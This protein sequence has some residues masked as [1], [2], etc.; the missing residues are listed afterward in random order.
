MRLF[1]PTSLPSMPA[2]SVLGALAGL[3]LAVAAVTAA[4]AA[5]CDFDLVPDFRPGDKD[6]PPQITLGGQ[7]TPL[8]ERRVVSCRNKVTVE[9]G[10]VYLVFDDK[11]KLTRKECRPNAPCTPSPDGRAFLSQLVVGL[12]GQ[13]V[14]GKKMD[15]DVKGPLGLPSGR[16]YSTARAATFDLSAAGGGQWSLTLT[17]VGTRTPLV[18]QSGSD[19]VFTVPPGRLQRGGKYEWTVVTSRGR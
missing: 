8:A 5:E 1:I 16:I 13:H 2:R 6:Y 18:Q 3:A 7:K 14:G 12:P 4:A 10:R 17:Q 19:R 11:G 9:A 15:E